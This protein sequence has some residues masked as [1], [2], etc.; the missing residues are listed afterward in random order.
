MNELTLR[1]VCE[2]YG[3]TRRAVQGYEKHRLVHP[4]GKTNRGYLLYDEQEQSI[5]SRVKMF[6][7]FGF[8]VKEIVEY[9]NMD[10]LSRINI[11]QKKLMALIENRES[12]DKNISEIKN[13]IENI[14]K[15]DLDLQ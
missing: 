9:Q 7:G 10:N 13:L 4:T 1:Q 8:S 15:Q 2:K 5:I 3:V 14:Q 6:Q 12:T 11:L